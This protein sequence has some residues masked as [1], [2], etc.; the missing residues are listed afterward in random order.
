M[1]VA[2][3]VY[4]FG[5]VAVFVGGVACGVA[6]GCACACCCMCLLSGFVRAVEMCDWR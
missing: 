3:V 2:V 4:V 1:F 6:C 5:L